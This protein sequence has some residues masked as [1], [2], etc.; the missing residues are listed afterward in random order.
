MW[1]TI[2]VLL[3]ILKTVVMIMSVMM[4]TIVENILMMI[5]FVVLIIFA[6]ITIVVIVRIVVYDTIDVTDV[7]F[8]LM[9]ISDMIVMLA[10]M[11]ATD[12]RYDYHA[13]LESTV[14]FPFSLS[15]FQSSEYG[16]CFHGTG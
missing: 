1:I 7:I 6:I 9:M 8:L 10:I 11:G 12:R 4:I 14:C 2:H 13:Y 16:L 15:I 3:I 5:I